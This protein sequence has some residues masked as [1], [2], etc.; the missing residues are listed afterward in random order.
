MDRPDKLNITD[1]VAHRVDLFHHIRIVTCL[2]LT[3]FLCTSQLFVRQSLPIAHDMAFHVFQAEQFIRALDDGAM[4][5]RW[6]MSSNGGYGSPNFIFYAPL[7]YYIV[8]LI[9]LA[10]PSISFSMILAIWCSFFLSGM[11]MFAAVKRITGENGA[12]LAALFY[13]LLP[14][15]LLDLYYRGTFS[16]LLAFA[17]FPLILMFLHESSLSSGSPGMSV[18]LAVSYAGLVLTHLVS[19]FIFTLVV[20]LYLVSHHVFPADGNGLKYRP[21]LSIATGMGMASFYLIPAAFERKYVQLNYVYEYWF[22]DFRRNFLFLPG[23]LRAGLGHFKTSLD[24]VALMEIALFGL[25]ATRL[26]RGRSKTQGNWHVFLVILFLSAFFLATP[27]SRPLWEIL[28]GFA[29]LQFPWRLMSMMELSLGFLVGAAFSSGG[30]KFWR[31]SITGRASGYLLGSLF[32][33]S[34]LTVFKSVSMHSGNFL[35]QIVDP[36]QARNYKNL[37]KEYTPIWAKDLENMSTLEN[38]KKISVLSGASSFTVTGWQPERRMVELD[39]STPSL[40]RVAT[41]YYPGWEA[42]I[43]GD[44]VPIGTEKGSGTMLVRIP[45]GRHSLVLRFADTPLRLIAKYLSTAALL[46]LTVSAA[47]GWRRKAMSGT[48]RSRHPDEICNK[49]I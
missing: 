3:A 13:Q 47:M 33:F 39:A 5:P 6:A 22:G 23:D 2:A 29:A 42:S 26:M 49:S 44:K 11:S 7:G 38:A 21:A 12:L 37:P 18:G 4:L 19:G 31:S 27:L 10:V 20:I 35:A 16:E 8:G 1:E 17:W 24:V 15:H 46:T 40:L 43:D 25:L 30:V 45:K 41:F 48:N 36:E 34:A 14:F 9:H 32:C 28:P